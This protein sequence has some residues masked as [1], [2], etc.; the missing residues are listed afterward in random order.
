MR[1]DYNQFV[2]WVDVY[3]AANMETKKMIVSQLFERIE[4]YRG[5][6]L[7]VRLT[8]TMQ[9]FLEGMGCSTPIDER[10]QIAASI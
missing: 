4:V 7:K 6:K 10:M 1:R 5:Y 3:D 8:I 9:Q 2:Q